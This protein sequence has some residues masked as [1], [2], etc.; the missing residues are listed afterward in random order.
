MISSY[1]SYGVKNIKITQVFENLIKFM[2]SGYDPLPIESIVVT[3]GV[4]RVTTIEK[5]FYSLPGCKL[6]ISG[7]NDP[8]LD[9]KQEIQEV[10]NDGFS[11]NTEATDSTYNIRLQYAVPGLGWSLIKSTELIC[12]FKSG[13]SAITPFYLVF[14]LE[15]VGQWAIKS[16]ICNTLDNFNNPLDYY[17]KFAYQII[18]LLPYSNYNQVYENFSF[19]YGNDSFVIVGNTNGVSVQG[20]NSS[21]FTG[22]S[23]SCFGQA[24]KSYN[25]VPVIINFGQ[26][27]NT[28]NYNTNSFPGCYS[29]YN[30][31]I[32]GKSFSNNYLDFHNKAHYIKDN[33]LSSFDVTA[34][35]QKYL[36]AQYSGQSFTNYKPFSSKIKKL[37]FQPMQVIDENFQKVGFIPGVYFIDRLSNFVSS[38]PFDS[39]KLTINGKIRNCFFIKAQVFPNNI[40]ETYGGGSSEYGFTLIDLTGPIN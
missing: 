13:S 39:I 1:F 6:V 37:E 32:S 30:I 31:P 10:F 3:S 23:I 8:L 34:T 14:E 33:K 38:G 4:A 40:N 9:T 26:P 7:T 20:F 28:I 29:Y 19:F 5:K 12:I 25:N 2:V 15:K 17:P 35:A 27:Y 16:Y 24:E 18:N 22:C 11:F 36:A 21:L